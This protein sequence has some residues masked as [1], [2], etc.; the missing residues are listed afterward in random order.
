MQISINGRDIPVNH[1]EAILCKTQLLKILNSVRK[2]TKE[3]KRTT[4]Y[5]TFLIV[6]HFLSQSLLNEID[7][8]TLQYIMEIYVKNAEE[9]K[10]S[11]S[12]IKAEKESQIEQSAVPISKIQSKKKPINNIQDIRQ[13]TPRNFTPYQNKHR[14]QIM[15]QTDE[16][17]KVDSSSDENPQ[18]VY[19]YINDDET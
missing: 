8:D 19:D 3:N 12:T 6:M 13:E 10:Q 16:D 1:K 7:P 11:S 9:E 15:S 2:I 14:T 18:Y 4:Y 5:F 17:I